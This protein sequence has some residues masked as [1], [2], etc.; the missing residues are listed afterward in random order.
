MSRNCL[1]TV[2]HVTCLPL[3]STDSTSD[4]ESDSGWV[5]ISHSSDE[6]SG[7]KEDNDHEVTKSTSQNRREVK[8]TRKR[9]RDEGRKGTDERERGGSEGNQQIKRL[10][11]ERAVSISQSR[12]I[13][14]ERVS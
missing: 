11:V 4:S 9:R 2:V 12:V 6:G 8:R 10:R 13:I 7:C 5:D 3:C 14:C 1:H